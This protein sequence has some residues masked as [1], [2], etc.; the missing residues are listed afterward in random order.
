MHCHHRGVRLIEH[1]R[2][3]RT[4]PPRLLG[5]F[6]QAF[7]AAR[8][9]ATSLP[10]VILATAIDTTHIDRITGLTGG[11]RALVTSRLRGAPVTRS[12]MWG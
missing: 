10:G 3:H 12:R 7:H 4:H 1:K 8:G 9:L 2:W 6:D 5:C 11:R